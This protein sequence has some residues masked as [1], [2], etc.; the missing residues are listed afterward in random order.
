MDVRGIGNEF[1]S[2][3][4]IKTTGP[5]CACNGGI[6]IK[7]MT[8]DTSASCTAPTAR[9]H[10]IRTCTRT[11]YVVP[12]T[13]C[14]GLVVSASCCMLSTFWERNDAGNPAQRRCG[15]NGCC[16]S[17][18]SVLSFGTCSCFVELAAR[19]GNLGK[20]QGVLTAV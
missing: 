1:M 10:L 20:M 18:S 2:H 4:L 15:Y 5:M 8:E 3:G 19:Q 17:L 12:C 11:T 9:C 7:S 14:P 6:N 13:S 16:W